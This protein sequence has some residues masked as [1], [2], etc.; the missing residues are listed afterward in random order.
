MPLGP[1]KPV[2]RTHD[3]KRHGTTSLF[4]ALDIATAEVIGRLKRRHR[5]T[6]FLAF[7]KEVDTHVPGDIPVHL[8]MDNYATHNTDK[9]EAWLAAHPRYQVHF[10]PTSASW[11]NR[12]ERFFSTLSETWIKRQAPTSVKDLEESIEYYLTTHNANPRPFRWYRKAEEILASVGRA[13]EA[14][15]GK[16]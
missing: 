7:L 15:N 1:E 10:T 2:T 13:V 11:L 6:A 12:V 3:Y 9:I 8:V 5:S 16:S 14:L 4:A